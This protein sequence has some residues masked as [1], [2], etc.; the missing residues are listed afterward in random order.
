[1]TKAS[2]LSW[3]RSR[4]RNGALLSF[5]LLIASSSVCPA[6]VMLQYFNTSYRELI[7]KMPELAEV[8]YGALWLPP[9]TKA[10]SVWSTGYD[11]W[12]PFDL[13]GKDQKGTVRTR[14]GTEK[15]L[16]EL[17]RVAHR[18]GIRVYF[19]N[20]MNHRA[21]DVPGYNENTSIHTYP[22]MLPEDFH[23]RV[24]EEGFYRKWD[25]VANWGDT[26]QVQNRNFSDLIDIAQETIEYESD[27]G[28]VYNGNFGKSEGDH[29]PKISFV[30]HPNNPE[31]YGNH[32]TL[33]WVGFGNSNITEEV[34]ANN[35]DDY[36]E[37]V[38]AYLIRA[39][40]WLVHH[41]RVDGLRLDAVKHVPAYFFGEQW[42]GDKDFS[43]AGYCGQ[44]QV[45]FN[46][47]RG[48]LDGNHRDSL[49]D[50]DRKHGRDDLMMFGEHL[51]EPP[52]FNN[53]IA[54][55]MRLVDSQLHGFLNGNL[56][57]PWGDI[58]KIESAWAGGEG[59]GPY[60]G[61][62]YVKSHD[63]D[64]AIRPE[65]HFA[66]I[67]TRQ[68]LPNVYTD[69]NYQS[70]TLG[71]SGGAFPRHANSA[72]LGQFG[73]PRIPNLVYIHEHFARGT[74]LKFQDVDRTTHVPRWGD[75]DVVAY[76]RHD[77]REG[78]GVNYEKGAVVLFFVMNDNYSEG[79]YR[80]ISTSFAPGDY[81]WQY[82]EGGGH[83]YYTVE[84]DWGTGKIRVITPPGGYFAF[85]YRTPEESDLWA[86]GDGHPI[87]IY[88]N[89]SKVGWISYE[90]QDGPDGDPAFNP[91][92]VS[93]SDPTDFTYEWYVPRVTSGTNLRFVARVDGSAA[94]V[95]IKLDGGVNLNTNNH[96]STDSRD[97]PPANEWGYSVFE[98][99]EFTD[100]VHRQNREKF[101][102]VDTVT[103]NVIG[104]DGA[105]T[106]IAVLGSG[107][108]FD[109]VDGATG[110]DSDDYTA[111]WIYHEPGETNEHS[112]AHFFPA[113]D[114]ATNTPIYLEVKV[115]YTNYIN[116][117]F[118]YYT[119]DGGE[120][121]PE[122]A[123]G[124]GIG[125]TKVVE[126]FE[127]Q[128]GAADGNGTPVWW[129][130]A[131]PAQPAGTEL[132][133]KIGGFWQQGDGSWEI[134]W[135]GGAD[136]V[137]RKKQ[138]MGVWQVSNYDATAVE[139]YP[140]NDFD[141]SSEETGLDE[142]MHVLRAR[143]FLNRQNGDASLY[144]TFVQPFYYDVSTPNGVVAYPENNG[145]TVGGSSYGVVVR[146][147]ST[148][149]DLRY[150]IVDDDPSNDDLATGVV[151]GNGFMTNSVG[152]T[153]EAW[154]VATE[155]SPSLNLDDDY[156]D[157]PREW[158]F[159]YVNIP[160]DTNA[161]IH[162]RM[163]EMSSSTNMA[164]SAVD[165]HFGETSRTVWV[166]GL[167]RRL[168]FDW[169]YEDG[170]AVK[171]GW[172]MRAKFSK[173][174][175][176]DDDGFDDLTAFRNS[177]LIEIDG[178]AQGKDQYSVVADVDGTYG[179]IEYNLPDK[180]S[181]DPDHIH[182]LRI[183]HTTLT[184]VQMTTDRY[185]TWLEGDKDFYV[186]IHYPPEYD[187]DG[188]PFEIF[189]AESSAP[190]NRQVTIEVETD[191][192]AQD[193]WIDFVHPD[194]TAVP[195][196]TTSNALWGTVSVADGTNLVSGEEID[197]TG[198]VTTTFSNTLVTG[199]N[200]LFLDELTA[201]NTI[202]IESNRVVVTQIVSQTELRIGTPWPDPAVSNVSA[203]LVPDFYSQLTGS[204]TLMID[205]H[206]VGVQSILSSSNMVLTA[207]WAWT[208]TNGVTAYRT[209]GNGWVV[210]NLM[211]WQFL[212]S[213]IQEG[214]YTFDAMVDTDG[215]TNTVEAT[216]RRN[217]R[218]TLRESVEPDPNDDDDDD[219]GLMDSDEGATED[220][221]ES[222]PET[223]NNGDVHIWRVYGRTDPLLPDS[224]SDGLPDGLESGWRT[225]DDPPTDLTADMDGDGYPNFLAD[226]DP[227]FFNT[228]DNDGMPEYVFYGTRTDQIHGS[229]TDPNN[230]DSDYDGLPDGIEDANRNGW[231][232]GDGVPLGPT[233]DWGTVRDNESKWPDGKWKS[234][235][236]SYGGRETDPN[237][238]DTDEDGLNDGWGE[239]YN[240]NGW[241]DGDSDS[242]RTWAVG[243]AWQETD[244]LNADTD[245]DGLPDGWE[246][247]YSFDPLNPGVIGVT[248]MSGNLTTNLEHGADGNPDGDSY[249]DGF[250]VTNDYINILEFENGTN[251]RWPDTQDPPAPGD[252]TIGPGPAIG[253]IN[254]VTNYQEFMDWS[255]N[256]LLILDQYEGAGPNNLLGDVY[257]GWDGWDESRDIVAFYVH[258]GGA[259]PPAGEGDGIVYFRIDFHDL[260][261][262]AEEGNLDIY[263][264]IDIGNTTSGEKALPDDIDARTEMGW[265]LVIACY[266]SGN[267][268]VYVDTDGGSN[269]QNVNEEL[270]QYGVI[271][272]GQGADHGFVDAY[273]NASLDA[274]EF[275]IS[276]T[277]L[278]DG[279]F[280]AGW[281]G[282]GFS[283]FN[284][285][286]YTTKDG[287][288]NSPPGSGDIGGRNDIRDSILDDWIAEDYWQSQQGLENILYKWFSGRSRAGRAKVASIVHGNQAIRP[289]SYIQDLVNNGDGAGY[290][291]APLAHE[292]FMQPLNLHITP[293]LASAI[294]WAAVDPAA[295]K[296]WL[297]GPALNAQIRALIDT[298]LV[299]LLGSTFSDHM[300]PY[301][302]HVY[303]RDNEELARVYLESI[304][305]CSIDPTNSVF[306]PPERLLDVDSFE[307]I[308]DMGFHY[309]V[310]DQDTHLFNW[311]GRQDALTDGAYKINEVR[312]VGNT[313]Y[314]VRA[315]VINNV[316]SSYRFDTDDGGLDLALRGLLSR[317]AY[318]W[319][320]EYD[321]NPDKV[322]TASQDQVI[323]IMSNWEDFRVNENA[324]AYDINLRWLANR[325]WTPIVALEQ[326]VEG[327]IDVT[328]DGIGDP[329]GVGS[330]GWVPVHRTNH[331]AMADKE[332]HNWLNHATKENYDNWYVGEPG[333][334]E[335]LQSKVFE[336]RPGSPGTPLPAPYGMLYSTGIVSQAWSA[337][338]GISD[339][340]LAVLAR[341]SL[342]ASVF[343]AA[344]HDEEEHNLSRYSTGEYM[345]PAEG[346]N[347]LT[348]FAV[349]AQAQ[350]RFAAVYAHVDDWAASA[351][352]IV[353]PQ[354]QQLDVDLDG[355]VEYVLYND[356]LYVLF[357]AIG[358]RM[359]GA[360]VRDPL[361]G[362]IYQALG[363]V[364]GY[365]GSSTE[366]EGAW[367]VEP[368][369]SV[370][371]HRTSGLKDWWGQLGG[372][373]AGTLAY[374][375]KMYSAQ[376]IANGWR[377]TS[378]S[379][380]AIR[381][382]I[383]LAP[384]A[385]ELQVS[386]D[387]SDELEG[388]VL[389]V[390]TGLSPNLAD[391][392]LEGQTT[393]GAV[394]E[395]GGVVSLANTNYRE[396][397]VA[398]IGLNDTTWQSSAEDEDTA[399]KDFATVPMRNQAQTHQVEIYGTDGFSFTL[400]FRADP[401]DWD[402]DGLPNEYEDDRAFLDPFDDTDG[403]NDYDEDGVINSHE[404]ISN[405][406]PNNDEDYLRLTEADGVVT[407]FVVRFPARP[408]R[409]Y[410]ISYDNDLIE[411]PGWSNATPT[412]IT[413]PVA[414]NYTWIDNGTT[415]TPHPTNTPQRFYDVG[416]SLP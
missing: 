91:Y 87:T 211:H 137:A 394:N 92:G 82:A 366:E 224:D 175:Y 204:D 147:D 164:L 349:V 263:V 102:A 76:E 278:T 272:H 51:G 115:G 357:E 371:A 216:D 374:V 165:G 344:F 171:E 300:L 20:I 234:S 410:N 239:D 219:D 346:S 120:S 213:D 48:F 331:V 294:E 166:D 312:N 84:D 66:Y 57:T 37:D 162:V 173:E 244:P 267:G 380:D 127:A 36:T 342:H 28:R 330:N 355:E 376:T 130:N 316:A 9:P 307:K 401:S 62:P 195:F 251:P 114:Q 70:E 236:Q 34:I 409:V 255:W 350:T 273:Y 73:D 47:T 406:D 220:L 116:R 81:L 128:A 318:A 397:V 405:T 248:N 237:K 205:G 232:D 210:G 317:K 363:N 85:S 390:R 108:Y 52:S 291:R 119:T 296:P 29:S 382:E 80:D 8:G 2:Y 271:V 243:E 131:I 156:P 6:E 276:R 343:Q 229:M 413:V 261:A 339:T 337:V 146:T 231:A 200:T 206:R 311:Y 258:D 190:S 284:Y 157:Y 347:S 309:A 143:A 414:T 364:A 274:V 3:F 383:T 79:Q 393:L 97:Y 111:D 384:H 63:D 26:W 99:Y 67:L 297:D 306:W 94:N 370:A 12:D 61:V 288:G 322:I 325:P 50:P 356:R 352:G 44:A 202:R 252:I 133:Y 238:N 292:V 209:E 139:F 214:Y 30:R 179:T 17:I 326:I 285:Q 153:N 381:K 407:G 16:L 24:T 416:V 254:G 170:M 31:Y 327:Q 1:M 112:H 174:L 269:S 89:D 266:Q 123:G 265:E 295:G 203:A 22:G 301:F 392:L 391:L 55:G 177:F 324:D 180:F 168:F 197:L 184:S 19:D 247:R 345:Y 189:F 186:D 386:Y 227:P 77:W 88:E 148:V 172:T 86:G 253:V 277:A 245:N 65:L 118:V 235:W 215:D 199:T 104:S 368:D 207:P 241:I 358:G 411:N 398:Y 323:T 140:H 365:A 13:G 218:I 217:V 154:A 415:T 257:K 35:P 212:W 54:A 388:K 369:G 33:G 329:A 18:F 96:F 122:G 64:Y 225:A 117:L 412:P 303:N 42:A 101:A 198:L 191:L 98:G 107:G 185:V 310:M 286:V 155:A 250:G 125:N 201:S 58:G 59:F 69:G 5:L 196:P 10:T 360:W 282:S 377:F 105:E 39:V 279:T 395:S 145:D 68:G 113:P 321:N 389:Y 260:K 134:I 136:A 287:T 159:S 230:Q 208:T 341:A 192:G 11:C 181:G 362:R 308:R 158:R 351:A 126:L 403:T 256:D 90:R 141:T 163:L 45:Q 150:R 223:W 23:L 264:V 313:D 404:W 109:R 142:G 121:W 46:L 319:M 328:A 93:D 353:T 40:R 187:S 38:N 176:T 298:N 183:T 335:G 222:N 226:Y 379:P 408:N 385:R 149:T 169:P 4:N 367:N 268:R 281:G 372:G 240:A 41:T 152:E 194:G 304:Y 320:N 242:N 49:F 78:P 21:F 129:T 178:E 60:S 340:N 361:N 95:L 182:H 293:T 124:E 14:Y 221:P 280:G 132:R 315:F 75:S 396:T 138:M 373:G 332:A 399:I 289:G 400:G 106:Y 270:T 262:L 333:V 275:G 249:V 74:D 387:L 338:Q 7:Q 193:V 25:N 378:I 135:P 228:L 103:R 27:P 43:D 336:I 188:K 110:R 53:Y 299:Y 32:P 72:F 354:T 151:N 15:E 283:N 259:A 302:T 161:T 305:D 144:N 56:G 246:R 375:N 83:F 290:H 160:A 359:T 402:G 100:F 167:D 334:E 314:I 348:A 71:E 233:E